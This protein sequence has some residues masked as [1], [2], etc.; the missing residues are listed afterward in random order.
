MGGI[1]LFKWYDIKCGIMG[2]IPH[3]NCWL[4]FPTENESDNNINNE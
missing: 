1:G 4:L 2:F 3:L